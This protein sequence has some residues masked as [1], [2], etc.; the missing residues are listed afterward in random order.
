VHSRLN[1]R[2]LHYSHYIIFQSD[3]TDI[4]IYIYI[5]ILTGLH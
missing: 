2:T 4:Y 1:L 5:Y 3:E